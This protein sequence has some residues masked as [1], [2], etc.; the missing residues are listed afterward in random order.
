[1]TDI[2]K[3][4]PCGC[5][6]FPANRWSS[7][8]SSETSSC[9][10][11]TEISRVA[12]IWYVWLRTFW[13]NLLL[14]IFKVLRWSSRS[15]WNTDNHLPDYTVQCTNTKEHHMEICIHL[16]ILLDWKENIETKKQSVLNTNLSCASS[17][18]FVSQV[19]CN[20]I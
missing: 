6:S 1:M 10:Y 11:K 8:N 5:D 14:L 13:R 20:Q 9:T 4:Y 18:L 7:S 12:N 19:H 2:S 16:F 15:F 3:H 17:S